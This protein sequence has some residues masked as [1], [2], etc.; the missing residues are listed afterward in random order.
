[1]GISW[2]RAGRARAIGVIMM[3]GQGSGKAFLG[4]RQDRNN[5][6]GNASVCTSFAALPSNPEKLVA[7][8]IYPGPR[9]VH[10]SIESGLH[11][12][13]IGCGHSEKRF[14]R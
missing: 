7:P 5:S 14:L 3:E 4:S 6:A 13:R 9:R 8:Q 10:P 1:M 11:G 12:C 2:L